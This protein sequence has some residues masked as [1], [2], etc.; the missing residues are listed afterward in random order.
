MFRSGGAVDE[1]SFS[2]SSAEHFSPVIGGRS[3]LTLLFEGIGPAGLAPVSWLQ[4][5][6]ARRSLFKIPVTTKAYFPS[7]AALGLDDMPQEGT[8]WSNGEPWSN[9][10]GWSAPPLVE[11]GSAALEGSLTLTLDMGSLP[12]ALGMGH[13]I[14]YHGGIHKIDEISYAGAAATV[15]LFTPLRRDIAA[16]EIITLRPSMIGRVENPEPFMAMFEYNKW[17]KPGSVTFREALL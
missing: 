16:G 6:I 4:D 9:G 17:V 2:A 10:Y 5:K 15:K 1:S 8:P 7:Q 12:N 11:A 3:F 14:G 13:V